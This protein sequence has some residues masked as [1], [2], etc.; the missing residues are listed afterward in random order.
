M[1]ANLVDLISLQQRNL[2]QVNDALLAMKNN[3]INNFLISKLNES[4][5]FLSNELEEDPSKVFSQIDIVISN[6]SNGN[7][8]NLVK[9][10]D[11][12]IASPKHMDFTMICLS[13]IAS[14]DRVAIERKLNLLYI[15]ND[16]I[17]HFNRVEEGKALLQLEQNLPL[18]L[19]HL[20]LVS[21]K[22]E[23]Q[24]SKIDDILK[25]WGEKQLL[26]PPCLSIISNKAN[27]ASFYNGMNQRNF[28]QELQ[29]I[30]QRYDFQ[31]QDNIFKHN[32][33][34]HQLQQQQQQQIHIQNQQK[35]LLPHEMRLV[36]S[37]QQQQMNNS[38]DTTHNAHNFANNAVAHQ[39]SYFPN[40][41]H[42]SIENS[43]Q[44]DLQLQQA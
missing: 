17:Y 15:I 11:N 23:N 5:K 32:Q 29:S 8:Q 37:Q 40:P 9:F 30:A 28:G 34:V 1:A 3:E 35:P 31:I 44:G 6:C 36:Q 4:V 14:S 38:T 2:Q 27:I 7:M 39:E 24:I 33:Y 12:F 22:D 41:V 20:L 21:H 42:G 43:G 25:I 16:L 10:I 19:H 18:F 13:I 26:S